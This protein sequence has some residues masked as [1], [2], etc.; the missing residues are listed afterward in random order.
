MLEKNKNY[1]FKELKD[2]ENE[3]IEVKNFF[4][5]IE[6]AKELKKKNKSEISKFEDFDQ[7]TR[8]IYLSIA[9]EIKKINLDQ[10]DLYIIASGS[11]VNGRWKTEQESEAIAKKYNLNKIKYSDYDLIT[12]AK[13]IPNL[14][15]LA[16]ELKVR[17]INIIGSSNG[18]EINIPLNILDI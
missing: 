13:N 3:S 14:I 4:N 18:R 8:S 5:Q 16:K 6:S 17:Y 1:T 7:N 9:Q 15:E 11:R 2:M 10:N 12:N